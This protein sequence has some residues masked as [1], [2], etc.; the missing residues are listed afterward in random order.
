MNLNICDTCLQTQI[1]TRFRWASCQLEIL[2]HSLP[3]C[4]EH[5]LNEVLESLDKTYVRALKDIKAPNQHHARRL[6]HCLAAATR[7]LRVEELAEVLAVD[8]DDAEGIPKLKPD[9]RQEDKEEIML[10]HCSSLI[11]I[12]Q[13]GDSR[14]V[15]FSHFSVKHFLTSARL[16]KSTDIADY[17]IDL[18]HA[19]TVLAQECLG[20]LLYLDDR[21]EEN[22]GVVK[23][24]SLSSP[25]AEY[26]AN[27]WV[28]HARSG[29][30]SSCL[31]KA[32]EYLFDSDKPHFTAWLH[33]HNIDTEPKP[34][35]SFYMFASNQD[36][37]T[38]ASPVY[39][40]A[41]HG[42]QA[43]VKYLVADDPLSLNIPGGFWGTPLVA[44]L[45]Q[46]HHRIALIL[47]EGGADVDV[48]GHDEETPLHSA[49]SHGNIDLV[50]KLVLNY[51]ADVNA[52]SVHNWT[53][54][55]SS[56]Q[57]FRHPLAKSDGQLFSD[58]AR[59]LLERGA[60]VDAQTDSGSTPIHIAALNGRVEVVRVLLEHGAKSGVENGEGKTPFQIAAA[61]RYFEIMDLLLELG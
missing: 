27:Y 13:T 18:E 20:A 61:R 29:G 39:Y 25:L 19:H 24:R 38:L 58:V 7:S 2:R 10:T 26:A 31:Q 15:E 46:G 53:P 48:R 21:V 9:W 37:N 8:L 30:V 50:S 43:L 49:A 4:I 6:F 12:I 55:H 33:V 17:H 41:L 34:D 1:S 45:A 59:L 54:L 40:A 11:A 51:E 28:T 36:P 44:A 22:A 57:G 47:C 23:T 3:P 32:M 42:F 60:D 35:S 56:C 14:I 52:R 16:A 5:T